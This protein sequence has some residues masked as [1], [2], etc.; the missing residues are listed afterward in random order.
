MKLNDCFLFNGEY[1]A[2]A[3][4][5][6]EMADVVDTHYVFECDRYFQ[7]QSKS[8]LITVT[9]AWHAFLA[10]NDHRRVEVR[11][12]HLPPELNAR[13]SEWFAR[14]YMV[15]SISADDHDW[16]L[17]SDCDEIVSAR[18]IS[19][20]LQCGAPVNAFDLRNFYYTLDWEVPTS[21]MALPVMAQRSYFDR[22]AAEDTRR[23]ARQCTVVHGNAGWH[24]SFLGFT[25]EQIVAKLDT[26]SHDELHGSLTVPEASDCIVDGLDCVKSRNLQLKPVAIDRTYPESVVRWHPPRLS[27]HFWQ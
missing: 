17:I 21:H 20:A 15:D 26:F 19:R 18:S 10:A 7:G 9:A 24:F 11:R 12:I 4:R 23:D 16:F 25:P 13:Q 14:N 8:S 27:R 2:L 5:F 22:H 6:A 1:D 3:I